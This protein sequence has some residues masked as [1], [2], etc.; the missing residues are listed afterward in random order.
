MRGLIWLPADHRQLQL[1]QE[2]THTPSPVIVPCHIPGCR[3]E[4]S[5]VSEGRALRNWARHVIA[6]HAP[7]KEQ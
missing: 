2:Q 7:K 5:A 4:A 1:R 3:Y 6:K